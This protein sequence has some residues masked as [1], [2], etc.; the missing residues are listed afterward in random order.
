M[1]RT[2]AMNQKIIS[3]CFIAVVVFGPLLVA[4]IR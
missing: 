2:T 1:E 4:Y 3:S